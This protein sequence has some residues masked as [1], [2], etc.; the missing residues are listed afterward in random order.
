[1]FQRINK[2]QAQELLKDENVKLVDIRDTA[3]Y[4]DGHLKSA[5]HLTQSKIGEFIET[6]PKEA[7]I[8]VI[9]YH[10]NSSQTIAQYLSSCNFTSVYSIDGG[11]EGWINE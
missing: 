7:P 11:Y 5:I 1:M 9:C 10:G 6:T 4:N 3:S 2:Q 8:L